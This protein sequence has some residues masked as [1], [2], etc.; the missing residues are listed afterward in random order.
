M[1]DGYFIID[2]TTHAYNLA[3]DNVRDNPFAKEFRKTLW[4]LHRDWNSPELI[5]SNEAYFTDWSVDLLVDTLFKETSTDL[6]A[7]H[8]LRLDSWFHD[9]LCSRE[10][11]VEIAN[12]W[13]DRVMPYLGVDPTAGL[14][15]CLADLRS[16]KAELPGAIGL[17]LYP[18]QVNPL[19]SWRMDDPTLAYPLFEEAQKIGIRTVAVHKAVPNGPV[20]LDP[21]RI[22]DVD[23]AAIHFPDLNF[24]IVH[25]GL[26]FTEE[27]ALAI[28]RFDNVYANLEITTLL[29]QR[30]PGAFEDAL[31]LFMRWAGSE[32]IIW[33]TGCLFC[34]PEPLLR[35]FVDFQFSEQMMERQGLKPL[36]RDDKANILGRNYARLAGIDIEE[37]KARIT[38]D[39]F[40]RY[41]KENGLAAPYAHWRKLAGVEV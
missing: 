17:K 15:V 32:R 30:A 21:Y 19:R 2:P 23:G 12:R 1:L 11:N 14:E 22:G 41:Q 26:A 37:R 20:P 13:P 40:A 6:S 34:H 28:A 35:K 9:G 39:E 27:T 25:S 33:S 24:E 10:K 36:S 5:M 8:Y 18:D 4:G 7:H 16:Q 38:D 3:D 31:A 29:L